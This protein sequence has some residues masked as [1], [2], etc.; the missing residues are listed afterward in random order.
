MKCN[1]QELIWHWAPD[2]PEQRAF[3]SMVISVSGGNNIEK[4]LS[5]GRRDRRGK[6]DDGIFS[7]V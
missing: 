5:Q 7:Q 2:L 1:F 6:P 4:I 3:T